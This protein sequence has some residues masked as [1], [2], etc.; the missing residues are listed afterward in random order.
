MARFG[1]REVAD[2][3]FIDLL[4]NKPVLFLDTLKMSNLQNNAETNYLQGGRGN[5][6][7]LGFD[8]N[9]T[10]TFE[11]QDAL[12]NPKA[13]AM[14]LGTT[15]ENK[16]EKIFKREVITSVAGASGKSKVSLAETPLANS[17]TVYKTTDGY[18][19]GTEV[20][21]FVATAKDLEQPIA[22]LPVGDMVIVYYQFNSQATAETITISSDKF[23]GYYKVVG[24]TIWRN[25]KT[26]LDEMAQIVIPKVKIMSEFNIN[27]TASGEPSVFDMK[28]DVFK[29]ADSKDMVKIIRY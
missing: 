18:E 4:T 11:I 3:T 20:S 26:G 6:R 9:R 21:T 29:P 28:L 7:I 5:A 13:I 8:F 2:V 25:E 19:Q 24:D 10:S 27:M 15:V 23:S 12:M 16:I 17:I 22:D 14:Q 1:V